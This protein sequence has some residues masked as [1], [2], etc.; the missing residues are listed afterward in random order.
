MRLIGGMLV[1]M[2]LMAGNR[3]EAAEGDAVTVKLT[4]FQF[5]TTDT[6]ADLLGYDIGEDRL[7]F[8]T[9]GTA[10][11]TV[12]IPADGEYTITVRA[13]C[14]PAQNENAKFKLTADGKAV[15]TETTLTSAGPKDYKFTA[16]LAAGQRKLGIEFTND[17][18]KEGE[19]DRNFYV[20]AVSLRAAK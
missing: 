19:Y 13:S 6:N 1:V 3:G 10:E 9:G 18:Y 8:Y 2:L 7:F 5:K 4:D 14:D 15:G 12:K 17:V 11:A 16:T 20:H